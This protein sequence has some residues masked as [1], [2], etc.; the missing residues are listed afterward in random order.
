MKEKPVGL[1]AD[2]GFQVGVRRTLHASPEAIWDYLLSPEGMRLWLGGVAAGLEP[3]K[4]TRYT[5]DDGTMGEVRAVKL[6]EQ[7]RLTWKP[8]GWEQ[9]STLQIRLLPAAAGR[10]TVSFHQEKLA[11]AD[12]RERMKERWEQVLSTLASRLGS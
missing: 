12:V 2:S 5:A 7:L 8:P 11:D 1:T 9:A 10:T 4:G 6:Q 3:V